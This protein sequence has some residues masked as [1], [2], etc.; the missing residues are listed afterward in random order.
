MVYRTFVVPSMLESA[1]RRETVSQI[2]EFIFE[3]RLDLPSVAACDQI[4]AYVLS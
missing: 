3:V 2:R 1:V 4:T